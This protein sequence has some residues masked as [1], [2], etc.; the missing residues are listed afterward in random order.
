LAF[1]Y[2]LG[3]HKLTDLNVLVKW[4]GDLKPVLKAISDML[5]RLS[6]NHSF[7]FSMRFSL[8]YLPQRS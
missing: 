6:F 4:A 3:E 5:S 8:I 7:D 1:L 2:W